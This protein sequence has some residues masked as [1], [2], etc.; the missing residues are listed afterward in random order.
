V[1]VAVQT[2]NGV[3]ALTDHPDRFVL[4]AEVH[5]RPS[6]EIETPVRA[7]YVAV[8]IDAEHREAELAHLVRLC[9][10][11]AVTPPVKGATHFSAKLGQMLL[12]WERHSEFSGYTFFMP[13]RSSKP[14]ADPAVSYLPDGWLEGIPGLRIVAAHAKVVRLHE[15]HPTESELAEMFA[16]NSPVGAEIGEGVGLAYTD[17]KI[18]KDGYSRFLII[19]RRLSPGQAGR[20]L[21]R[22]FEIEAYRMLAL[23]A[24]PVARAQA[25]QALAM[26][27]AL[28]SVTDKIASGANDDESLLNELTKL[29]AQVESALAFSQFRFAASRAYYELVVTRI[30]ELRERRLP[31]IQTI[32]EFMKRRLA[33]AVAT[34]AT[35]SQ[36]LRD[37]SE[38]IA[39]TS[40][41]LSTRVDITR[42]KQNQA[43]LA[44]MER[45]ARLQLRLQQTVE[46]LSIAAITYYI[47]GLASYAF[48]ALQGLGLRIQPDVA[49]GIS[50]PII[51]LAVA[52]IVRAVRKRIVGEEGPRGER[53]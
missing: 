6:V 29:A 16:D 3:R 39:Q 21:Q 24:L 14:F 12:K 18:H 31:G 37:L 11:L 27:R 19:N 33:P 1:S 41:L 50:I 44:S 36:R 35:I 45:R 28:A 43:L 10:R 9:E 7:S 40:G 17:F 48:K 38:R 13:N 47:V 51:V 5:A 20:M 53:R 23:L 25:P 4:A 52:L 42:E 34:S 32:D 15:E 2:E 8:L 30:T 49:T 22:L 26:E 46:G